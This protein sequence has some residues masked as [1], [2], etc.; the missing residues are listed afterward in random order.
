MKILTSLL[1]LAGLLTMPLAG[2]ALA[3]ESGTAKPFA[4]GGYTVVP[5]L[6]LQGEMKIDLFSGPLSAEERAALMPGGAAPSSVNIFLLKGPGGNILIDAGWGASGPGQDLLAERL[7]SAGLTFEDVDLVLLTHMHPDHIGGLLKGTAPAFPK[8]RVLVSGPELAF[9]QD[10]VEQ[11][12]QAKP[13]PKGAELNPQAPPVAPLQLPAAVMTAYG[14]RLETFEF[15]TPVAEGL[16]S[17]SAVGHT[18]GHTVFL[19]ESDGRKLLFI[20]DLLHAALLQFPQPDEN[21]SYDHD[22]A[23]AAASRRA[24]LNLAA[25]GGIPVAGAHIPFP[26]TGRVGQAGQGF[27]FTPAVEGF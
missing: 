18:P 17:M 27:A 3:A 14:D 8:A 11:A 1:I 22:P 21:S 23:Q 16:T 15:E 19:L 26:G 12:A 13:Q 25:E 4:I 6:D 5:I 10:R 2:S 9:W 24:V 20:G 7:K